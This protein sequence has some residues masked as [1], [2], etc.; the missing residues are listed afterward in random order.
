MTTHAL[1]NDRFISAPMHRK[2]RHKRALDDAAV[3]VS[4]IKPGHIRIHTQTK[5]R[6]QA[7]CLSR[8]PFAPLQQEAAAT[9][10][11]ESQRQSAF[12]ENKSPAPTCLSWSKS[13][14][15]P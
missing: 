9:F 13:S 5:P 1:Q 12:V 3:S 11:I 10:F 6:S 14:H 7:F 15:V 4:G 8:A 2:Q